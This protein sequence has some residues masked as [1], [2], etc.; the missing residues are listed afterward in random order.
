MYLCDVRVKILIEKT[1]RFLIPTL[2]HH[3]YELIA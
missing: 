1:S 2:G 3:E